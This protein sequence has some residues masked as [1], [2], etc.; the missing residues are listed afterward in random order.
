MS[1]KPQA[2]YPRTSARPPFTVEASGYKPVKGETIPR[3]HPTSKNKLRTTPS[4]DVKTI[5]DILKRSADKYGNAKAV[6]TRRLLK[7]HVEN[8]KIKKVVDGETQEVDKKWT[9]FEL[10]EYS[11][12]SFVEYQKLALDVGA[13]LRK[14]GLEKD[15][16]LHLYAGTR[17]VNI[18][19]FLSRN[20]R[21]LTGVQCSL[22]GHVPWSCLPVN[23]NS[24][25]LRYFGR[26]R[27]ETFTDSDQ[28]ESYLL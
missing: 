2:L 8:K 11:Y 23:A 27:C 18:A 26:G 16:R 22:A 5:F 4:E 24:Y 20:R 25:S 14:I 6:G 28:R 13:G 3:R 1:N 21:R 10:S 9:Y 19:A 17:L 7:T 15:D 12:M